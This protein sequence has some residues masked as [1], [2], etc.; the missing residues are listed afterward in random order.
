M[1]M[2][3]KYM[4]VKYEYSI[5]GNFAHNFETLE[6]KRTSSVGTRL[7]CKLWNNIQMLLDL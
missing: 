3:R 1:K 6:G 2:N 5:D 4:H 7:P